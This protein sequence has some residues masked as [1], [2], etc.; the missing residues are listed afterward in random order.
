MKKML[1]VP[2]DIKFAPRCP[3]QNIY[4]SLHSSK[5]GR[6]HKAMESNTNPMQKYKLYTENIFDLQFTR[7]KIYFEALGVTFARCCARVS[8]AQQILLFV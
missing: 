6:F 1:W 3:S 7:N 2:R 8:A 4:S 5:S